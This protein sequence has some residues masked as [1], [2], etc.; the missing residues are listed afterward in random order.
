MGDSSKS[1]GKS[2]DRSKTVARKR[3][4][5]FTSDEQASK[6][7]APAAVTPPPV[8]K[9][10]FGPDDVPI[11]TELVGRLLGTRGCNMRRIEKHLD[12]MVQIQILSPPKDIKGALHKVQ[13]LGLRKSEALAIMRSLVHKLQQR[14]NVPI[15]ETKLWQDIFNPGGG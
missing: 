4:S 10:Y 8:A 6:Q 1:R 15:A 3:K 5:I 9:Q 2:A 13:I 14:P 7:A 12:M 11:P